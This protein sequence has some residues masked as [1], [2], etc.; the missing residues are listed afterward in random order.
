MGHSLS[1]LLGSLQPGSKW[2]LTATQAPWHLKPAPGQKCC[3][4]A[5]ESHSSPRLASPPVRAVPGPAGWADAPTW[6]APASLGPGSGVLGLHGSHPT[7]GTPV[8]VPAREVGRKPRQ[9][10]SSF[11]FF[12]FFF[13]SGLP[14]PLPTPTERSE[15]SLN[16]QL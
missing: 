7:H 14:P 13:P 2:V 9:K 11:S 16:Q 6:A 4:R 12:F 3:C 10:H 5:R 8:G 1:G 15:V